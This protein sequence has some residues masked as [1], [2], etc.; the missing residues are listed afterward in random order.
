M[1]MRQLGNS[2]LKL[3]VIGLGTWA[4][5][6]GDWQ[7]GWGDQAESDSVAAIH[8]AL[9]SGVNWIDT[10]PAYGLGRAEEIVGKV[11]RD[12][13]DSVIVATKCGLIGDDARNIF[14]RL[15]RKSILEEV[16]A[17]LRRLGVERIDLYQIHWPNPADQIEEAFETLELLR[18]QGKV[19]WGGVSNFSVDQMESISAIGELVSLQPPYSM[20]NRDIEKEILPW[21]GSQNVGIV[22][23]SPLQCGLLTGKVTREWV[24]QLPENDWRK[25]KASYFRD[26]QLGEALELVERLKPFAQEREMTLAQLAVSWVLR[27]LEITSAIV[28]VRRKGQIGDLIRA[29]ERMLSNHDIAALETLVGPPPWERK[30]QVS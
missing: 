19:R 23:Y 6:G 7:Y 25:T 5:G 9:D 1:L 3:S 30:K 28:G 2:D 16:E 27:R 11:L 10:A 22:S 24:A 18:S 14:S 17:S 21:C 4:I 8:E 29:G 20:L 26:P 15:T 13:S 12:R